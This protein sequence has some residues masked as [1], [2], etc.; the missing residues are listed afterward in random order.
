M[1]NTVITKKPV[2]IFALTVIVILFLF[3]GNRALTFDG[4]SEMIN[5]NNMMNSNSWNWMAAIVTLLLGVFIGWL[6]FRKEI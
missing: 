1:K 2:S 4:R 5:E 6:S 3:F